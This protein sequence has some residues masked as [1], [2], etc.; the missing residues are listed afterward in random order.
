MINSSLNHVG[1]WGQTL[2][3]NKAI[4]FPLLWSLENTIDFKKKKKNFKEDE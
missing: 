4:I 2:V 1:R 3:E